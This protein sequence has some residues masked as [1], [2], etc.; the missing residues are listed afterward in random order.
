MTFKHMVK[1]LSGQ[2]ARASQHV[3]QRL[4]LVALL[5]GVLA[6]PSL[7]KDPFRTT[8]QQVIGNK[9][10]QAFR[11]MFERGDYKTAQSL[12]TQAE[13]NEPLAYALRASIS[14]MSWESEIDAQRKQVLLNDFKNYG[15]QTR[16]TA[17]KLVRSNPLRGNIYLAAGHFLEGAYVVRTEGV[18]RGTPQAL[19][20]LQQA[21]QYLDAAERM[22]PQ[23]PELNLLKGFIDLMLSVNVSLPLSNPN[24]AIQRL[25]R[26]A[27]PR[28]LADRGLAIGFRDMKQFDRALQAV[29]RAIS[30]AP[31]NPE[32]SYLKAQIL[33]RQNQSRASIPLF[34]KALSKRGQLPSGTVAQIERELS[35]TKQRLNGQ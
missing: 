32:L 8:N 9:T 16:T 1:W 33:V 34:E 4:S 21:F 6:T 2:S 3:G 19:G 29:D 25:E 14:Y 31:D 26:F 11:A 22:S 24:D 28:Y 10:E 23:D 30:S 7:A 12:L 27:G 13:S 5:L 20:K 35:K 15:I 17:E 18:V